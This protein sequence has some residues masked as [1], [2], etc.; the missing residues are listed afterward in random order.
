MKSGKDVDTN[1][2]QHILLLSDYVGPDTQ[3]DL[4]MLVK[5]GSTQKYFITGAKIIPQNGNKFI[6]KKLTSFDK[7]SAVSI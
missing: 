3:K 1:S 6:F 7:N 2:N 5:P 4:D